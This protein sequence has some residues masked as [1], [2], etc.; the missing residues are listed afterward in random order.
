MAETAPREIDVLRLEMRASF[1]EMRAGFA[2]MRAALAEFR[3]E[4]NARF[5]TVID[6]IADLRQDY[7]GHTHG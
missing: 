6:A 1:A 2:E 7:Q 5:G 3:S 4:T